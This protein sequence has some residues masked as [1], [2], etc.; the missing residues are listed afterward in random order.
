[1]RDLVATLDVHCANYGV[2]F[3]P[4]GVGGIRLWLRKG[5]MGGGVFV[6]VYHLAQELSRLCCVG[7]AG[8]RCCLNGLAALWCW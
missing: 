7:V 1:M 2:N 6:I 3:G 4:V 8:R 5:G